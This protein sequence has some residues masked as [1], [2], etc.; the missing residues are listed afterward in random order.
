MNGIV[1]LM[2]MAA[3]GVDYGWQPGR[4]GQLEYIV[5]IEP[6]LLESLQRGAE[7]VSEI[8]PD[9]RGVRRFR[10]RVGTGPLPRLGR[11]R[12]E[13]SPA[14]LSTTDSPG[15]FP[16]AGGVDA[17]AG[18]GL[19]PRLQIEPPPSADGAGD[20]ARPSSDRSPVLQLPPPPV[21]VDADGKRSVLVRQRDT[22][23]GQA[24]AADAP[25]AEVA[26]RP[27]P[28]NAPSNGN[29]ERAS[30][31]ISDAPSLVIPAPPTDTAPALQ[32]GSQ[33][34]GTNASNA[35]S[36]EAPPTLDVIPAPKNDGRAWQPPATAP[37]SSTP[38]ITRPP[39]RPIWSP[40]PQNDSPAPI[41]DP[42]AARGSE[43][44]RTQEATPTDIAAKSPEITREETPPTAQSRP[45]KAG[46]DLMSQL[47]KQQ[48]GAAAR[49]PTIDPKTAEKLVEMQASKPWLPLVFTSL[50]LFLSIAANLYLGWIAVGVFRRY[51]DM[52]Q[53]LHQ[54]RTA[55]VA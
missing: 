13:S 7:I 30:A 21:I 35:S 34:P 6:E 44:E 4:D 19:G 11:T 26:S 51:R 15:A 38:E 52:A 3:L 45:A 32:R 12:P 27:S 10:I 31:T 39:V 48:R 42:D 47:A 2:S 46:P 49:K 29:R 8:H 16:A 53:Q 43:P 36:F 1:I 50:A 9:A 5:Q 28:P 17:A 22:G 14:R 55:A 41:R 25:A 20:A 24:Q 18:T 23:P 33:W 37:P 54:A 40:H